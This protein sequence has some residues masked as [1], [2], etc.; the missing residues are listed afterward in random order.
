MLLDVVELEATSLF[1]AERRPERVVDLALDNEREV[2][3]HVV[4]DRCAVV[5]VL[6]ERDIVPEVAELQ[7]LH[8]SLELGKIGLD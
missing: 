8:G 2:P 1:A 3:V 7:F 6:V 4:V 5:L